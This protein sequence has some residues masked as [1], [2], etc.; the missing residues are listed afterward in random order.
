MF[1]AIQSATA[2]E[3]MN[4]KELAKA[5]TL[6][7]AE[8]LTNR[9]R[10]ARLRYQIDMH[11]GHVLADFVSFITERTG[12]DKLSADRNIRRY[13]SAGPGYPLA[14]SVARRFEEEAGWPFGLLDE[15]PSEALL[16][17]TRR[18]VAALAVALR[19]LPAVEEALQAKGASFREYVEACGRWDDEA[20]C[21]GRGM[22]EKTAR[23]VERWLLMPEGY[24][25]NAAD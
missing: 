2:N 21:W 13:F 15:Q 18:R 25:D 23:K 6:Q 20:G 12:R 22:N 24:L 14:E 4:T 7:E 19:E 5:K 11:H 17:E 10:R 16:A 3:P 8:E 9:I 1:A